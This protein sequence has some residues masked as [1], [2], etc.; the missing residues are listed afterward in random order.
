MRMDLLLPYLSEHHRSLSVQIVLAQE[1]DPRERM[2]KL[3]Y[4]NS[5]KT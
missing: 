5:C 2:R 3:H 1:L 4:A